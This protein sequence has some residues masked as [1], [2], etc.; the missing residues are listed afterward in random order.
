MSAVVGLDIGGA[1]L[2]AAHTDGSARLQAFELWKSP[3]CLAGALQDLLARMPGFDRLA[4][5]MT[6]ELC[7]CYATKREGVH[8]ILEAV[9]QIAGSKPVQVWSTAGKFVDVA[10][11][12]QEPL[13]V[14]AANWHALATW[15]SQWVPDGAGLLI[16][17]GSTTTDIIPLWK[18]KP[19]PR[20][21][22]DQER[23]AQRELVYRGVRRTPLC[24]FMG[25]MVAAEWFATTRDMFL[26]LEMIGEDVHDTSTADGRPATRAA[27]HARLARMVGGDAETCPPGETRRLANVAMARLVKPLVFAI[28]TVAKTLP[29]LPTTVIL[30]GSGEFLARILIQ[31]QHA[32]SA[33]EVISLAGKLGANISDAACAYALSVLSAAAE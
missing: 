23:I 6:G 25:T 32:F 24:A 13:R 19:I 12:R 33:R 7:D 30:A 28:E 11:A 26:V 10:Q 21:L 27:A 9:E 15:V 14:A 8:A 17:I 2:K 20:G 3:K 31:E 16:D 4:V 22:T 5:T 29:Q 18:G 1:N